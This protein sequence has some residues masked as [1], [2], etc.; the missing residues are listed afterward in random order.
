MEVIV[1]TCDDA[2]VPVFTSEEGLVRRGAVAAFGADMYQWGYQCGL[3]A[4]DY[5]SGRREDMKPMPVEF[6]RRVYNAEK[7]AA[8][9]MLFDSSFVAVQ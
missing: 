7:A 8:F 2:R 5:L 9:G 6:R 4:A 1:K 3:Q